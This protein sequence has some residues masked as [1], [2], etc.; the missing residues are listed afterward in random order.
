ML[1]I[2]LRETGLPSS[3]FPGPGSCDDYKWS[4]S[5][6]VIVLSITFV[7]DDQRNVRRVTFDHIVDIYTDAKL[8]QSCFKQIGAALTGILSDHNTADKEILASRKDS[9]QTEYI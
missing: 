9:N 8:L 3:R 1:M 6:D 5:L 7:T 2:E 4:G